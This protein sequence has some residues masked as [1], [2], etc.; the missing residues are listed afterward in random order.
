MT[1]PNDAGKAETLSRPTSSA[2]VGAGG[3]S[4]MGT[5]DPGPRSRS[6][7]SK[8]GGKS[9]RGKGKKGKSKRMNATVEP[10]EYLT[11]SGKV[12]RLDESTRVPMAEGKRKQIR[13]VTTI[14]FFSIVLAVVALAVVG[15]I[16]MMGGEG[17]PGGRGAAAT[18]DPAANPYTLSFANVAG[19]P[20]TDQTV[21]VIEASEFSAEWMAQAADVIKAGLEKKASSAE[22]S[23]IGAGATKPIQFDG[24]VLRKLPIDS[25]KLGPWFN[26][27]TLEGEAD[28]D[29]AIKAAIE[30]KPQTLILVV[31]YADMSNVEAWEKL[32]AGQEGLVVHT[33]LIGNSSPELQGWMNSRE[34]SEFVV[35]SVDDINALKEMAKDEAEEE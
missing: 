31:G 11:A 18:Y 6:T 22:V 20:L 9:K 19:L 17:G 28:F 7:G 5:P 3:L 35:L 23:L 33:V 29:A 27:L 30:A 12:V 10:G 15:I 32:V 13:A 8:R 2:S 34:G 24:G 16:A 4:S 1:V 21:V 14:V 25:A 26:K